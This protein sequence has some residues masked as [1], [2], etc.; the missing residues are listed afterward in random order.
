MGFKEMA[1]TSLTHGWEKCPSGRRNNE[2][3]I[4]TAEGTQIMEQQ[5]HVNKKFI[6]QLLF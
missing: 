6:I 3:R 5:K 2:P 1:P 4:G